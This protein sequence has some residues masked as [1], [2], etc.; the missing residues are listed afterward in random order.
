MFLR[1]PYSVYLAW[2]TSSSPE[3][4]G[5]MLDPVMTGPERPLWGSAITLGSPTPEA[6]RRSP[7]AD[8]SVPSC[9]TAEP[10][11]EYSLRSTVF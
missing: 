2:M 7:G 4:H 5:V 10:S 8:V 9:R 3:A 1:A 6:G 11:T